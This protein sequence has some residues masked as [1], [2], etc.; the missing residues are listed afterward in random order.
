MDTDELNG[1]VYD[2]YGLSAKDAAL[3]SDWFERRS[4][5]S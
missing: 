5:S 1:M 4:L 2:L 3:I